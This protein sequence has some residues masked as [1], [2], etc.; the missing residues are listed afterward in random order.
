M[1][2]WP[3]NDETM[4]GNVVA[5]GEVLLMYPS[6]IVALLLTLVAALPA[7]A[8]EITSRVLLTGPS[9][10]L[11]EQVGAAFQRV[12]NANATEHGLRLFTEPSRGTVANIDALRTGRADFAIVQADVLA[13]ARARGAT[14]LRALLGLHL[15]ALT[16]V[17]RRDLNVRG[18]GDL[19]GRSVNLAA[20][21]SGSAVM[22]AD[23]LRAAGLARA[24]FA[25]V[26][27]A[28][29]AASAAAFCAGSIDALVL[30]TGHPRRQ[31]GR[32]LERCGGRLVG[33][34]H[35]AAKLAMLQDAAR[36]AV[37]LPAGLYR[38]QVAPVATVGVQAML[39]TRADVPAADVA[40]LVRSVV[41]RADDLGLL[42][43]AL[44]DVSPTTLA[45]A[46][47]PLPWH[48]GAEA[49]FASAGVGQPGAS[50]A[51]QLDTVGQGQM[52]AGSPTNAPSI[53]RAER[54]PGPVGTGG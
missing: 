5:A 7:T 26:E 8:Q 44:R 54:A 52:R 47:L 27:E 21:G 20:S 10:G 18:I 45:E 16:V 23:A 43:F 25:R 6:P 51:D 40:T 46:S 49:A 22:V 1:K 53:A 42:T 39:I 19:R 38:G 9:G 3:D 29:P 35:H 2:I 4:Y 12:V 41:S 11:Y 15:E 37:T 13:R 50:R 34:D 28:T 31:I 48:D 32:L 14:D 36:T 30:V 17:A 24:D 33:F